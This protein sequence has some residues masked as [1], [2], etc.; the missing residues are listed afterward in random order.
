MQQKKSFST[1][2]LIRQRAPRVLTKMQREGILPLDYMLS[3]I[4][5]PNA[6][7]SRR[8]KMAIAAAPYCHP[9]MTEVQG[10]GKKDQQAE[11]AATAG[12]GTEWANDLDTEIQAN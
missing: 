6:S 12:A 1:L 3:V 10:K 11:A 4:R 7:Q 9:R 5:D 2:A 8:D